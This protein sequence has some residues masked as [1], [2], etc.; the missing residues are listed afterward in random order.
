MESKTELTAA[1]LF[2]LLEREFR[3]RRRDCD[4]CSVSLPFP[5]EGHSETGAWDMVMP[6][7]CA[8]GCEEIV[9]TLLSQLRERYALRVN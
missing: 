5:V 4:A 2:V 9:E 1:D 7:N 8:Q 6:Q 3:R